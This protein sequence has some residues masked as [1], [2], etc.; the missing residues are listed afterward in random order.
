MEKTVT[1]IWYSIQ[2]GEETYNRLRT[3]LEDLI[4]F[5]TARILQSETDGLI[6]IN[7]AQFKRMQ[8]VWKTWLNLQVQGTK[9]IQRQRQQAINSNIL[10][11]Q[12]NKEYIENIPVEHA[13]SAKKW[14]NDG[15]FNR[16][17]APAFAENP[18]LT[19]VN[20]AAAPYSY[21][22]LPE[23]IPF[24]GWDYLQVKKF[25]SCSCLVTMYGEYIE[26]I[27]RNF[28]KKLTKQQVSFQIALSDCVHIKQHLETGEVYDRILT[29]NLMDYIL[30]PDLLKLCS[31]MLNHSNEYATIITETITWIELCPQG[32]ITWP[33]NQIKILMLLKIAME[34]TKRSPFAEDDSGVSVVEY[35]DNSCEFVDL[36]RALFYTDRLKKMTGDFPTTSKTCPI[37]ITKELGN[38][39]QL[40]LRDGVRN[41]NRI[42]FFRPA[43]NRRRVTIVDGFER[44]L[45]WVPLQKK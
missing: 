24:S 33:L 1:E 25:K 27:L 21:C 40:C 45:E 6:S 28:M 31:E 36:L 17:N 20:V 35:L 26:C 5:T 19:G 39:F 11:V 15:M 34:D 13:A 7:E 42:V 43:I 9:W 41:E 4:G 22:V 37:P 16:T 3:S 2:L 44:Y 23:L 29:S 38:E 10:V 12:R 8:D 32:D 30:L 14:I 18:T